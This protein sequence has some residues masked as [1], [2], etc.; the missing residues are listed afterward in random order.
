M[1]TAFTFS[2]EN[3]VGEDTD[4]LVIM[5]ALARSNDECFM[6]MT[7][8]K[9]EPQKVFNSKLLQEGLRDVKNHIAFLHAVTGCDTTSSLFKKGKNQAFKLLQSNET[10]R[11]KVSAFN[12]TNA[13]KENIAQAGE[14]LTLLYKGRV[15]SD[16]LSKTSFKCYKKVIAKQ[17]V[18]GKFDLSVLPPTSG[19]AKQ[20]SYRVFHQVQSWHGVELPAT[21]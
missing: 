14:Y 5:I 11:Q 6:L 16:D 3:K 21:D 20:Q 18:Y 13:T 2:N 17:P 7:P 15:S 1:N 8:T 9:F 19:A 12:D 4:L 10:L